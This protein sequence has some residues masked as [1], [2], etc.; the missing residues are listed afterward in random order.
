MAQSKTT[1]KILMVD[2][3][4]D[5]CILVRDALRASDLDHELHTLP[6]GVELM[7]Y[8]YQRGQYEGSFVPRPD[9]V[10]LD[11]NMPKKDG[12]EVLYEVRKDPLLKDIPIAVLTGSSEWDDISRCYELGA[13]AVFNKSEWFEDLIQIMKICGTYWFKCMTWEI[14]QRAH[15]NKEIGS[16]RPKV[17]SRNT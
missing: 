6:D 8:L 5:D 15:L 13:T 12:R 16:Q 17:V 11:L 7:D 1:V 10:L 3:D 4:E 9:L 2:D 14:H